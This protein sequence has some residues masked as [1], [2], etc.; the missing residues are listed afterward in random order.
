MP[1]ACACST[2]SSVVSSWLASGTSSPRHRSRIALR[3]T[4]E[5]VAICDLVLGDHVG[6][7]VVVPALV[8]VEGAEALQVAPLA[9][10]RRVVHHR[11]QAQQRMVGIGL[12]HF[13][14]AR[15]GDFAAQ[16]EQMIGAQQIGGARR[17]DALDRIRQDAPALAAVAVVADADRVEHG[18]DA[19]ADD[20]RIVR[21][22]RR[23]GRRPDRAGARLEMLLHV[24]GMDLDQ[25]RQQ[26][27]RPPRSW[28]PAAARGSWRRS[29]RSG[30]SR[31]ARRHGSRHRP[32]PSRAL[33]RMNVL[34]MPPP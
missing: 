6:E 5:C 16:V 3:L 34:L 24:V 13:H 10:A 12:E 23:Q 11:H 8:A 28:A 32:S 25:A 4:S 31:R 9:L 18:G 1:S 29:R 15:I 14:H 21:Q 27:S 20:L 30:R 19:G 7:L 22:H 2:C 33:L 26:D 17:G